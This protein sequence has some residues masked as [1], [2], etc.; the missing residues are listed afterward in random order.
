MAKYYPHVR[1]ARKLN[2]RLLLVMNQSAGKG[3]YAER[4]Q[5][6]VIGGLAVSIGLPPDLLIY[7]PNPFHHRFLPRRA[8]R[9]AVCGVCSHLQ[10]VAHIS[11]FR[12]CLGGLAGRAKVCREWRI[13]RRQR[14]TATGR[15]QG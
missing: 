4:Q 13:L 2:R 6:T 12:Q 14:C 3:Q 11:P 5:K 10:Q 9:E 1:S 7:L 15:Y 8:F